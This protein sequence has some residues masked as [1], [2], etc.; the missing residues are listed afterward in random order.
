MRRLYPD[1]NGP[2]FERPPGIGRRAVCA[3]SGYPP[4]PNCPRCAEAWYIPGVSLARPCPVH[5]RNL[6]AD[7]KVAETWPAEVASFL[8]H[9]AQSPAAIDSRPVRITSP[10]AGSAYRMIPGE[11][12]EEQSVPLT[13]AA[14][15]ASALHW[16]INDH[17]IGCSGPGQPV[18]WPLERGHFEIVC[19]DSEGHSDLVKIAV[20]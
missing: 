4:G 5:I 3:V 10:A 6:N 11:A 7:G 9:N 12:R 15:A 2:A 16:F 20:N 18:L 13:A 14:G 1:N 8:A 19:S 17:Y